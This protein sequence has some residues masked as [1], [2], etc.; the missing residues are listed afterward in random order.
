MLTAEARE[1]HPGVLFYH[2]LLSLFSGDEVSFWIWSYIG[3]QRA[4]VV[5]CPNLRQYWA[6]RAQSHGWFFMW[7][8]G[9][10]SQVPRLAQ[11]ALIYPELS[12]HLCLI[13]TVSPYALAAMQM[14]SR[15]LTCKTS[16]LLSL[17]FN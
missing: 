14:E 10:H 3:S 7:V 5:P 17:L 4:I 12:P 15:A 6:R 13:L 8:L 16:V 11:Q 1:R 9:I 2:C